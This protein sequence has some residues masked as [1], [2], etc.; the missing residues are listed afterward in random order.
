MGPSELFGA[1]SCSGNH[2]KNMACSWKSIMKVVLPL[3]GSSEPNKLQPE[4]KNKGGI[5]F[6]GPIFYGIPSPER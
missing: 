2:W 1:L 3:L 6:L 5:L 4:D